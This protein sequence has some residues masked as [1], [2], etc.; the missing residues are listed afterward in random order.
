MLDFDSFRVLTFD[1][2][3]TLI[4]WE[5]GILGCLRPLLQSHGKNLSDDQILQIYAGLEREQESGEYI[6]YRRVLENVVLGFGQKLGFCPTQVEAASLP[7]SLKVWQPFPDTVEALRTLKSRYQ[8]V[9]LS[10][11]DDDLFAHTA[12]LLEVPFDH[13]ITAQQA[14]SYK[15]SPRNFELALKR[16]GRPK[17]EV[18]HVA[19]SLHH[20]IA[21]ARELGLATVWIHRRKKGFGATWPGDAQPDVELPDL[22]SLADLGVPV[23]E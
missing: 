21:P 17:S 23:P 14:G 7:E 11:T 2:Y 6:P 8:L 22:A 20:D 16:V 13:V 10:N 4:N 3:G 1:C 9:I 19:E 5:A 15:P 18:L 12:K